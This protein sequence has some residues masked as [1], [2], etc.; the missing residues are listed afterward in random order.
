MRFRRLDEVRRNRF[1]T[2]V[3]SAVP[4]ERELSSGSTHP[5]P[6]HS[7]QRHLLFHA[8]ASTR[9]CACLRQYRAVPRTVM[10]LT[11]PHG[12]S[13]FALGTALTLWRSRAALSRVRVSLRAPSR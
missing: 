1:D 2:P 10:G 3:T 7:W 13:L 4:P 9:S 6:L 11:I 12:V 5:L 8:R